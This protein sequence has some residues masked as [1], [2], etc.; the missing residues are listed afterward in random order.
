M[1]KLL[2]AMAFG[3]VF[4]ALGLTVLASYDQSPLSGIDFNLG[5]VSTQIGVVLIFVPIIYLLFGKPLQAAIQERNSSLEQT[6][7][8]A[9]E[10]RSRMDQLKSEYE[11]RLAATEA[12]AREQIQAQI[13]E[14]QVLR[15]TMRAESVQQAEQMKRK[16]IEEIEQE[17]QKILTDLR[18]HVVNLTLMATE[19]LVGQTVDSAVNRK[20]VEDFIDKVEVPS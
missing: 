13:K 9:E 10:L 11:Q 18:L 20:L 4:I 17:K 2:A 16:A 5:K 3:A 6:F 14:A 8:E 12:S 19:K 7:E 15:D 1:V